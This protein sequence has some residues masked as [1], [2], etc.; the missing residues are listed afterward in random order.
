VLYRH[1]RCGRLDLAATAAH[2]CCTH[3]TLW[4]RTSLCRRGQRRL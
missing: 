1:S 4:T 2:L 3:S